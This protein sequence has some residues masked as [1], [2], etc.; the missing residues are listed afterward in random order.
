MGNAI[1]AKISEGVIRR[2]DI[3]VTTKLWNTFHEP[4]Q[5]PFAFQK[6]LENLDLGYIDLYLIHSPEAHHRVAKAGLDHAPQSVDDIEPFPKDASGRLLTANVD[7]IDTWKAMEQLLGTGLV[8]SI[9]VSNFEISQIQRL[10]SA[11]QIKPVVNQIEC[12]PNK[13]QRPTIDYCASQGIAV[14][15]YS[16]LGKPHEAKGKQ[17]A[18]FDSNIQLIAARYNKT[19]AQV[20][21]RFTVSQALTIIIYYFFIFTPFSLSFWY[22]VRRYKMVRLL[23]QNRRIE[24]VSLI[25]LIYSIL[26]WT[27][28]KWNT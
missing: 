17:I 12:H 24:N 16:P 5:V 27:L 22:I 7:F 21:L 28:T 3:F 1:R 18:L 11:A 10:E 20:I 19:P 25:I 6:S 4:D 9:G 26:N 23:F 14:T 8:R 2:E 13:N 15:A